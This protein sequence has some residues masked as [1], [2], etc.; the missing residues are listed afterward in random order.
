MSRSG[1]WAQAGTPGVAVDVAGADGS[2]GEDA[3][4]DD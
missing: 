2:W 3:G 4:T 1:R